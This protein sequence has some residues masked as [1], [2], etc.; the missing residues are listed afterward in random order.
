MEPGEWIYGGDWDNTTW[1]D[2]AAYAFPDKRMIDA[3]TPHNPVWINRCE[4][5][6]YLANSLALLAA[7]INSNTPD[8]EGGTVYRYDTEGDGKEPTGLLADNA[9]SLVYPHVPSMTEREA[10]RAL[11]AATRYCHA[12]GV[13]SIVHMTEPANRNR[14]GIADDLSVFESAAKRGR[15]RMRVYCAVPIQTWNNLVRKVQDEGYGDM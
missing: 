3:V 10:D 4:G 14:G 9:L 15:L 7:G 12:Y 13:T 5:H 6:Q 8:V 2:Y 11:E 1:S